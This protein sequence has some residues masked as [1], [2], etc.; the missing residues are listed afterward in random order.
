[1][2]N[3]VGIDIERNFNLRYTSWCRWNSIKME[4]TNCSV[5]FCHWTFTLQYVDFN[6]RLI[7]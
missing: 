1:M 6:R 7:I 4:S 5:V 2:Q 3:T